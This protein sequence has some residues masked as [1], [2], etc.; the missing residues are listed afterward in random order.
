MGTVKIPNN[1]GKQKLEGNDFCQK[2]FV[3]TGKFSNKQN[4]SDGSK[5]SIILK[6]QTKGTTSETFSYGNEV[7]GKGDTFGTFN[8][9]SGTV[10]LPFYRRASSKNLNASPMR[11]YLG[12]GKSL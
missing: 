10:Q 3:G 4:E 6:G 2:L 12:T 5:N 7:Y 11:S 8:P 9:N 1:N